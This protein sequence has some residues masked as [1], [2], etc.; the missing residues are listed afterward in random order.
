V[1]NVRHRLPKLTIPW[2][3]LWGADDK[4]APLPLGQELREV[5]PNITEF[6]VIEGAG[7]Q[8]QN[9]KPEVFNPLLL[10]FLT[11]DVREPMAR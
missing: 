5:C 4:T 3:V 6:H 1:F 8:V 10:R 2:C 11:A 9:D 7:H